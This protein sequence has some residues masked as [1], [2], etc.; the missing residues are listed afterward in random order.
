MRELLHQ[1]HITH[2]F[3]RPHC[4]SQNGKVERFNRTLATEWAYRQVVTSNTER[5]NALPDFIDDYNHRR[6][7]SALG[8]SHPPAVC[9]QPDG[10][11]HLVG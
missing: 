1:R 6:R 3:I 9:H 5:A 11:V 10:R 7:D 8:A 4:L 2:K